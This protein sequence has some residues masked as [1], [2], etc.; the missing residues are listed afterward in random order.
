[1]TLRRQTHLGST[2]TK[3]LAIIDLVPPSPLAGNKSHTLLS[4]PATKNF[5]F[6]LPDELL[7]PIVELAISG[8]SLRSRLPQ[9]NT[10]DNDILLIVSRVCH[11]LRRVAQP[12]LFRNIRIEYPNTMVPPS[13]S[14]MKLHRTLGERAD[15]RQ[16]CR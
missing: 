15:L 5:I 2:C 7:V 12:L 6:Q 11:R 13:K 16:H 9:T 14:L 1:M 10:R 3:S 8:P 4:I